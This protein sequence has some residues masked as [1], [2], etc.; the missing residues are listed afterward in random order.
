[1][2]FDRPTAAATLAGELDASH[3]TVYYR[4]ISLESTG[5]IESTVTLD[6]DGHHRNRFHAVVDSANLTLDSSGIEITAVS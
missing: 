1:M 6:A 3:P 5:V 2:L 4:L